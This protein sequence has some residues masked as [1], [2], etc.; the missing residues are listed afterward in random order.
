[1][2]R[3]V[4]DDSLA[5]RAHWLIRLR[6]LAGLA[7][8]LS[9]FVCVRVFG[10]AL[11]EWALYGI[12]LLLLVYNAVLFVLVKRLAATPGDH[13]LRGVKRTISFQ[14]S[15][16]LVI[17]TVMLHFSGGVENPLAFFFIFHMIIASILLSVWESDMQ[18]TLAV[19]LFGL[20]ALL[21]YGGAI[22][23]YCLD[24]FVR[25]CQYQEGRYVLGTVFVFAV[26]LYLVVYMASYIA[27]R[28]RRAERA[29]AQANAQ[30]R[31]KDRIKDEYVVRLTHDLKGHLAAI[32]TCLAVAIGGP[33]N[34]Q[35]A[36]FVDRAYRRTQKLTAF[37][38]MLLK[39]TKMRLSGKLEMGVLSVS[40]AARHAVEAVRKQAEDKGIHLACEPGFSTQTVWADRA[41]IEETIV[42]LLLNA[43]KYTPEKGTISI[44]TRGEEDSEVVEISDTGI[45]IP[46]AE[47]SRVFDEFYRASNAK[48]VERTG[49]GLGL[50]LAKQ[51]IE[52]HDGS[53]SVFSKEGSGTTFRIVLPRA[54]ANVRTASAAAASRHR[55]PVR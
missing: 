25:H 2:E 16:D 34:D 37:V 13:G 30:L 41:A 29:Q 53:I 11:E 15:A 47:L 28:L 23:H 43:I 33:I 26:T 1:M 17:L 10:I 9:T 14:I 39:L 6:W 8:A 4:Q 20:L 31:E 7:V 48:Q 18:A 12:A 55:V 35:V 50:S 44:E 40:D 54:T 27:V 46:Q 3:A 5:Q 45:G 32:Q 24:G 22:P 51:V 42:N 38:R 52:L 21:E 49:S 36:D 19:L